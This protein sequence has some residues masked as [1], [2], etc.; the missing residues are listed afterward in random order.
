MIQT[1][2]IS[3]G[4]AE[5]LESGFL[6]TMPASSEN[7]EGCKRATFGHIMC[8]VGLHSRLCFPIP[9]VGIHTVGHPVS[10]LIYICIDL[11][12][13]KCTQ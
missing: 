11:L 8:A 1:Q 6:S 5:P 3:L 13:D 10:D 2:I 9:T 7:N 4:I 12:G